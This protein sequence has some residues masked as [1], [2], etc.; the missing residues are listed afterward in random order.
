MKNSSSKTN[1]IQASVDIDKGL[2]AIRPYFSEN[3]KREYL[4]KVYYERPLETVIN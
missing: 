4:F 2:Y 3:K 1:E